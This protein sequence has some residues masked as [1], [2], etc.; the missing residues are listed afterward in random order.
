VI[1]R[2]FGVEMLDGTPRFTRPDG[3]ALDDR[4]PPVPLTT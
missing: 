4:A 2:G 1:H 3:T